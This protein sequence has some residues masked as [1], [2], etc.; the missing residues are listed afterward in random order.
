MKTEYLK[1]TE[2]KKELPNKDG[3]YFV[4]NLNELANSRL[5][6]SLQTLRWYYDSSMYD[7]AEENFII[8][9]KPVILKE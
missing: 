3:Y 7:E 5:F 4:D 2:V 6:F 9:Y 1:P 8:W